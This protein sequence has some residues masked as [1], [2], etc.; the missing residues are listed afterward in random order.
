L[1]KVENAGALFSQGF[2]CAQ[3]LL[4]AYGT[5]LGLNRLEALKIGSAF[6]G[7]IGR[8]GQTCGA[9]TGALMV[10]GLKYGGTDP[11]PEKRKEMYG[12]V[13]QFMEKFKARNKPQTLICSELI[14]FC[15]H[16]K[17]EL[18]QNERNVILERC[19]QFVQDAAEIIEEICYG[20]AQSP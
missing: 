18:S 12:A 20:K 19:T 3:S 10:I 7:G 11:H 17:P 8:M 5:D 16:Q 1:R 9:V 2:N 4:T 13:E 14:G 6:G 15:M